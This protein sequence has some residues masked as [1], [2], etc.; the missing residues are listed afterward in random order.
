MEN[1]PYRIL[2]CDDD[3]DEAWFLESAFLRAG[4]QVYLE[5]FNRCSTLLDHL[6]TRAEVPD[7]IFVDLNM[8]GENGLECLARIKSFPAYKNVPVMIYTTSMLSKDIA[9]ALKNGASLYLPKTS[10]EEELI[11]MVRYVATKTREELECPKRDGFCY[12]P[13]GG[14]S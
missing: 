14:K 12:R 5:W 13:G 6:P 4:F 10:S 11:E 9:E 8:P 1:K 2:L 3:P 7:L